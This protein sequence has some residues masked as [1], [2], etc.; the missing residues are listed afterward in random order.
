[1]VT[2]IHG[3]QLRVSQTSWWHSFWNY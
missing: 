3:L 1:M 2:V